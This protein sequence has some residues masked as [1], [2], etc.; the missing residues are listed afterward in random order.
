M[1]GADSLI[2]DPG[3]VSTLADHATLFTCA[4]LPAGES[5]GDYYPWGE[6]KGHRCVIPRYGDRLVHGPEV[7]FAR[8]LHEGGVSNIAIIKVWANFTRDVQQW[9]WGEGGELNRRW[10]GFAD[11]RLAELRARGF[12]PRIRGFVWH[13]GIDDAIH[14]KL[15]ASYQQNLIALIAFLRQR[16]K[17]PDAPFVLARSVNSPIARQITGSSSNSPMAVVRQAQVAVGE[18]VP[19]AAW[20]NVDDLPNVER[21]HFSA[22]SQLV[23]GRRFGDAYLKLAR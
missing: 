2:P 22:E 23:I 14:G 17:A 13:Q 9:P 1:A 11:K 6:I 16:F 19:R 3:F 7:G 10:L 12:E 15:S 20:V 4:P 5:S 8:A 21:H 18:N